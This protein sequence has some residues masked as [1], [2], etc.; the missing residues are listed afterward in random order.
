MRIGIAIPQVGPLAD[1]AATRSVAVA[2]DQ[3]GYAS[4]WALDRLLAPLDPRTPYP[5]SPDGVLPPEQA[6]VLDPIGV[7]TLAASV[8]ERVRV[9]T[10][11]LVGPWYPPVLL[12]RSLAT[13]DRISAGRL[14]VG[15]GLGW[16][17]DEYEAVG[18]PQ[19]HLAARAEEL[20][21]VLDAAWGPDPVAYRGERVDVAPSVIGLKPVQAGGPPILL[22]AYTP[23]GLDRVARRATGWTPAGLPVAAVAPMWAS[24]RDMA[25]GYHRDPDELELVVRANVK[26]SPT[27]LG[28][29]RPSYW[30]TVEQVAEDLDATRAAGAHEVIV[31]VQGDATTAAELL[32]LVGSLLGAAAIPVAA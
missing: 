26:L 2:A 7:L 21:D 32:D 6:T 19:R 8:T 25:A 4:L 24:V 29:D 10:N 28:A 15:L 1:P 9:G 5:A 16:S 11:V 23:A 3:A 22:A 13:L 14:T 31:D 20:L 12:A 27:P 18:V 30:G 17:K